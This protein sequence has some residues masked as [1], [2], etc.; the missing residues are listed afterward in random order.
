MEIFYRSCT[1][2]VLFQRKDMEKTFLVAVIYLFHVVITLER[3]PTFFEYT[4]VY[5]ISITVFNSIFGHFITLTLFPMSLFMQQGAPT[6]ES[7]NRNIINRGWQEFEWLQFLLSTP[8]HPLEFSRK[9]KHSISNE[10]S[11]IDGFHV[12]FF[13]CDLQVIQK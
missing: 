13:P 11:K 2:A 1:V 12:T 10:L 5:F 7:R 6:P 9:C 8:K 3:I 4:P